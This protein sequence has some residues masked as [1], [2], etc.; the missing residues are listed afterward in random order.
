MRPSHSAQ[1][2]CAPAAPHLGARLAQWPCCGM[3]APETSRC[4]TF[5]DGQQMLEDRI[6]HRPRATRLGALVRNSR[7][8]RAGESSAL[9]TS[10][11]F[12][13]R[14]TQ[15]AGEAGAEVCHNL[16]AQQVIPDLCR[17]PVLEDLPR[18]AVV[19]GAGPTIQV[20]AAPTGATVCHCEVRPADLALDERRE[21]VARRATA[22]NWVRT[23]T[24]YH[25]PTPGRRRRTISPSCT[26]SR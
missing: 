9:P 16:G 21:G 4:R 8:E 14:T 25:P 17:Q 22:L 5:A 23:G 3:K 24:R 12:P 6:A 7:A 2:S 18:N 10:S 13:I 19:I 1:E 26:A 11:T 20:A 15:G